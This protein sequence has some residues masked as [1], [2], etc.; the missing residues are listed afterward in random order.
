MTDNQPNIRHSKLK[1]WKTKPIQATSDAQFTLVRN[2]S[3]AR[4][5]LGQPMRI[6]IQGP[7]PA[8][9]YNITSTSARSADIATGK[10]EKW[11]NLLS[12]SRSNKMIAGVSVSASAPIQAELPQVLHEVFHYQVL[13]AKVHLAATRFTKGINSNCTS[14]RG[15]RNGF[16]SYLG[17]CSC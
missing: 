8:L 4:E 15:T 6:Q 10:L 16:H 1:P 11:K 7:S 5:R 17:S 3:F 13:F 14:S 9:A 12:F 2:S